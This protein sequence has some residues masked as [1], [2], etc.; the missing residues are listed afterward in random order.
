LDLKEVQAMLDAGETEIAIDE[1]RWLLDDCRE[2]LA[3]HR[4][5]GELAL[6]DGDLKLA[7]GHF[8]VAF[9]LGIKAAEGISRSEGPLGPRATGPMPYSR[10][11]NRDFYESGKALVECLKQLGKTEMARDVIDRLLRLDPSDPLGLASLGG[12]P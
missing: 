1:L 5:L 4:M 6:A 2:F 3:A 8:G 10:P 11:A 7:R 9:Q 12:T